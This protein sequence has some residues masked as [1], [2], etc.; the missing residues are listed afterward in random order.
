[1]GAQ[2]MQLAIWKKHCGSDTSRV[3]ETKSA[4]R[5][6]ASS[7]KLFLAGVLLLGEHVRRK[8]PETYSNR[9]KSQ[10]IKKSELDWKAALIV[11]VV[12]SL[13]LLET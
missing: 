3:S 13:D 2:N 1:M 6:S 12:I 4:R 7:D 10:A 9:D 8:N 11:L 5:E